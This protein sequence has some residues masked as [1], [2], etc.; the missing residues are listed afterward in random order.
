MARI[1]TIKPEFFLNED[2]AKLSAHARLAFIGL[3]NHADRDGRLEDRPERLK[4]V[5]F[6]YEAVSFHGFLDELAS[7]KFIIRYEVEGVKYIEIPTFCVHQRP[8]PKE[9]NSNIPCREKKRLNNVKPRKETERT[10]LRE[11]VS[12][13]GREGV[14]LTDGANGSKT[15]RLLPQSKPSDDEWFFNLRKSYAWLDVD[16]E[17]A[18]AKAWL[19]THPGRQFTRRF[20]VNWLNK[21]DRPANVTESPDRGLT[22]V[23]AM[24]DEA[25]RRTN[26]KEDVK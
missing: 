5:I 23:K 19:M 8:H 21:V 2:L 18:K 7:S 14:S 9:P 12:L 17:T 6:P 24:A 22:L 13:T 10:P 3:W 26:E 15:H 11:G 20:F 16:R 4:A 1:R 25:M